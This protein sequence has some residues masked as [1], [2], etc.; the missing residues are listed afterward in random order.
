[1]AVITYRDLASRKGVSSKGDAPVRVEE[2]PLPA[3]QITRMRDVPNPEAKPIFMMAHPDLT[4]QSSMFD[5]EIIIEGVKLVM[6][7][8]RIETD[9]E[10]VRNALVRMGY[11]WMNE[12]F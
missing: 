8:G 10:N 11:R 3:K 4:D 2:T 12:P 7:R 9:D 6:K 5:N 1:M